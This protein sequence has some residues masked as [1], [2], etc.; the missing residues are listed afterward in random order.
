[1]TIILPD[2]EKYLENIK[3]E[4]AKNFYDYSKK[5]KSENTIRAYRFAWKKFKGWCDRHQYNIFDP[6][7]KSNEFLV[8]LFIS[9]MAKEREL[10]PASIASYIIGLKYFYKKICVILDTRHEEIKNAISGIRRELGTRQVQKTP[11]L[12]ET[13]KLIVQSIDKKK[14]IDIR[15][16]AIILIGFSGAFR[17]S[18]IAAIKIED[19]SFSVYGVS[20]NIPHSKTDQE[21]EGRTVDIPFGTNELYCPVF[22][23][24]SWIREAD[25]ESGHIFLRFGKNQKIVRKGISGHT[26]ALILKKRCKRFGI[27]HEISGHS[28]RSG[29]VT[30]AIK[31]GTPESWIMRQTGHTNLST[32]MKYERL[33]R[34]FKAN[35]AVK[36]G[37]D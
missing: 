4:H 10:R 26:I 14:P 16:K 6:P 30:A 32:L 29:H 24:Q 33:K 28:L 12:P 9:S 20:I 36:I 22:S 37:I 5:S 1:M 7:N 31:S 27:S 23:L 18:E 19:L 35:S 2:N 21:G 11:L 8:G 25:I 34:E 3:V 15:D 13:I 17:R